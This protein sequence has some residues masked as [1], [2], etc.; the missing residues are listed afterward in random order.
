LF[1]DFEGIQIDVMDSTSLQVCLYTNDDQEIVFYFVPIP[2]NFDNQ[3]VHNQS[4]T[5]YALCGWQIFMHLVVKFAK[6]SIVP[7][8]FVKFKNAWQTIE[9]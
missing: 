4:F 2:R 3:T 6:V 9:F 1:H 5:P 7:V 8:S